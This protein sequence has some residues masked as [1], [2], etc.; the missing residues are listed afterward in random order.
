MPTT[1]ILQPTKV[2]VTS[3]TTQTPIVEID[4]LYVSSK[5]SPILKNINTTFPKN[6]ITVLLGPSG[7]GKTTLLKCLNRLTDLYPDL[8]LSGSI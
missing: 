3:I 2:N 8:R 7:C 4:K 1:E 6:K 5:G